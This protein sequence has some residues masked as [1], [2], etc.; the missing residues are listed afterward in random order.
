MRELYDIMEKDEAQKKEENTPF[1]NKQLNTDWEEV[2]RIKTPII[3]R[4]KSEVLNASFLVCFI[5]C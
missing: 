1:E 4:K 5:V 3:G 2:F